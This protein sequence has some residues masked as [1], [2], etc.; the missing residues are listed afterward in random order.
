[1]PLSSGDIMKKRTIKHDSI[2]SDYYADDFWGVMLVITLI[3]VFV[4]MI[5]SMKYVDDGRHIGRKAAYQD[6]IDSGIASEIID[7][8]T[9]DAIIVWE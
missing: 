8:Y 4:I 3:G 7:D 1:M 9:G 2:F 6:A 5:S